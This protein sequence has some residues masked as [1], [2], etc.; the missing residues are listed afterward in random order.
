MMKWKDQFTIL[1]LDNDINDDEIR[2]SPRTFRKAKLELYEYIWLRCRKVKRPF[3][4][5]IDTSIPYKCVKISLAAQQHLSVDATAKV[6]FSQKPVSR[7]EMIFLCPCG[8]DQ[9]SDGNILHDFINP[10][11]RCGGRIAYTDQYMT[12]RSQGRTMNFT[13]LAIRPLEYGLVTSATHIILTK[14]NL[15]IHNSGAEESPAEYARQLQKDLD[16][17]QSTNYAASIA[18]LSS[19]LQK[20]VNLLEWLD[21]PPMY[22]QFI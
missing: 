10:F 2:I 4:P 11:F 17:V 18:M 14:V 8:P 9:N 22:E 21:L 1:T 7:A 19:K 5:V 13:V 16:Y 3:M 12:I 15:P 20:L 6:R